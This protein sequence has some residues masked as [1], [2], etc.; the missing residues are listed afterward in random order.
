MPVE[1]LDGEVAIADFMAGQSEEDLL[2]IRDD[3]WCEPT[4]L[5]DAEGAGPIVIAGHTPT[6]YL[7]GVKPMDRSPL[8]RIGRC[9][10]VRLGAT[11]ETGGVADKWD[12]DCGAAGGAGLGQV[13][14]LRLDDACEFMEPVREGE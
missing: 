11:P 12:I 1:G 5:L 8:D 10:M 13:L 6:L 9:R 3:F 2:W 7:R 4:G 14:V